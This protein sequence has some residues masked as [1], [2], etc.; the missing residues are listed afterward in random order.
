MTQANAP[1]PIADAFIGLGS[2]L[3]DPL[4]QL[5]SALQSLSA[6]PQTQLHSCSSLYR[7]APLGFTQQPD[8]FNA[9]VW[10]RT[11]L[12]PLAL[13]AAM[14]KI[15]NEQG[16]TRTFA[17]APRTLD[18]DLLLYDQER[19]Q[20]AVLSLPH[21][22]LHGRVFAL[23]PLAEIAADYVIPGHGTASEALV[24]CQA[25]KQQHVEILPNVVLWAS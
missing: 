23:M 7:S 16:R 19:Y 6:L 13:L 5:Q 15:E 25:R 4:R 1:Q 9:V 20:D 8:F 24:R 2:N 11:Q 17:N 22:R 14:Q 12:A 3:N 21:P 18:L 10:L